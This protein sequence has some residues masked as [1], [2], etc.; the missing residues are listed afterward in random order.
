MALKEIKVYRRD[1]GKNQKHLEASSVAV[2]RLKC[3]NMGLN[4]T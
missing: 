2:M 3:W 4:S 1:R